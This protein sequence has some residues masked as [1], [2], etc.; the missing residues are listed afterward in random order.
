M[1]MLNCHFDQKLQ[2]NLQGSRG[3]ESLLA[4][5]FNFCNNHKLTVQNRGHECEILETNK[6][7]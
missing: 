5:D 3:K 2:Q 1:L 4:V 7:I 6:E